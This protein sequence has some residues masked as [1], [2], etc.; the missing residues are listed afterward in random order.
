MLGDGITQGR[1]VSANVIGRRQPRAATTVRSQSSGC[2]KRAPPHGIP[3]ATS[4]A[5]SP[6]VSPWRTGTAPSPTNDVQRFLHRAA[7]DRDAA[8]RI[9]PVEHDDR[10][11]R[12]RRRAQRQRH[13]PDV[14]V[15]A[16]ADV[17]QID[18]QHVDALQLH[19]RRRQRLER[20]A[21]EAGDRNA[22]ARVAPVVDADHVLRLA[23]HAVLGPEQPRRPHA[24]RD[25][26]IDDVD[27]I[28]RDAGRMAE[29]AHPAPAQQV[30][31][32][33]DENVQTGRDAH[34]GILRR[35]SNQALSVA[36]PRARARLLVDRDRLER[37]VLAL[38]V[39]LEA[40]H[41]ALPLLLEAALDQAQLGGERLDGDPL[42][43]LAL[44]CAAPRR[45]R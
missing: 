11:L 1:P 33:A 9:R 39:D 27:Q 45:T 24:R 16:A 8:E 7:L 3:A 21:V 14:R 44:R 15:V 25:Q 10:D 42:G 29:H 35:R 19:R 26:P 36:A 22:R 30:Q 41:A 37:D 5:T 20:L 34:A 13:R 23:A 2:A 28:A 18:D 6:I 43:R 40:D 4:R 17:L 38:G 32:I 31:T 12:P